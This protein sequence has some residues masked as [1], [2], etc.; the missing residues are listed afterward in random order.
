MVTSEVCFLLL[1]ILDPRERC[2]PLQALATKVITK[3]V[4]T[5]HNFIPSEVLQYGAETGRLKLGQC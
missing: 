5:L 3:V 1:T 2:T 4:H